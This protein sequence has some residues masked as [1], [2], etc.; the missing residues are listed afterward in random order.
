MVEDQDFQRKMN[1]LLLLHDVGKELNAV[2]DLDQLLD[3]IM[4]IT[5]EVCDS[6]GSSIILLDEAA[7]ELYFKVA[8]GEKGDILQKIRLPVSEQSVAGWV[9]MHRQPAVINDVANDKRHS[10]LA[11]QKAGFTTKTL[12]A[13]PV[14]FGDRIMGVVEA[15]NKCNNG[16]FDAEDLQ[17][18]WIMANQAAVALNNANLVTDLHNFFIHTVEILVTAMEALQP[19]TKGHIHRVVRLSAAMG[20]E[21]ELA[22]KDYE[23]LWYGA[24]F[25]DIGKL[26]L[27]YSSFH[28]NDKM[29]P[30]LGYEMLKQITI[31]H[32][33]LP[34][35]R[36]H[37]ERYD[38][39]G[40]PDGLKGAEIPLGARI[41][42]IAEEYD[43]HSTGLNSRAAW[44]TFHDEFFNSFGTRFDP[45][46]LNA[47]GRAMKSLGLDS[48][49]LLAAV[50]G[51]VGYGV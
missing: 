49:S 7:N 3:K 11:D 41:V 19:S 30:V 48:Y 14:C 50:S 8:V 24:Y 28:M 9:V 4:R 13:V 17:Y 21:L 36:H 42:A 32:P 47:F 2:K 16:H 18:L 51:S 40:F 12:L 10:K 27:D 34:I 1:T 25:H 35:V 5:R 39:T 38:G 29:H 6:E 44:E 31:L 15:V 46:L 26:K 23:N 22:G 37:H 43:E 45:E 33:I 20:R